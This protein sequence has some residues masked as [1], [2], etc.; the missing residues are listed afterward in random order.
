MTNARRFALNALTMTAS[1]LIMR[2]VSVAFNA[3]VTSK[4]GALGMGLFTLVMSV[5][6]FTV[7]FATSGIYLAC[8]RL[9]AEAIG[10]GDNRGAHL[11]LRRCVIY[12]LSFGSVAT[13]AVF[14]G[15]PFIGN[16]LLGDARTVS[17]LRLLALSMV[18]IA[19][20]TVFNGYFTAIRHSVKNAAAQIFEQTVKI[21]LITWGLMALLPSGL[22]YA[23]I[24]LV[25]GGML[26]EVLSFLFIFAEYRFF[27]RREKE[28]GNGSG[29]S[30]KRLLHISLPVA[31]SSYVRSALVTAEHI[32]IPRA[33]TKR[34]G[35]RD[36][37]IASYGTLHGMAL[38]LVLYPTAALYSFTGLLIPEVSESVAR[39]EVRRIR[40]MTE[41]SISLT[42]FFAMGMSVIIGSAA[43][44][45][46]QLIYGST[47]A[48]LYI[49]AL[50]PLLP[51]MYLDSTVDAVL[52]GLGKQVYSM[53][54]N[55]ID[56]A[57]CVVLVVILLPKFGA[58]GYVYVIY[59]SE[60]LNFILSVKH[61]HDTVHFHFDPV[62]WVLA[63]LAGA[64]ASAAVVSR[65]VFGG[66]VCATFPSAIAKILLTAAI[67]LLLLVALDAFGKDDVKWLWGILCVQKS[68]KTPKI[69]RS[70][71]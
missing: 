64:C 55:I 21:I 48:G 8:T 4:V 1:A 58:I 63:P 68:K 39:G 38:P 18:P 29:A 11:A 13:L 53:A 69:S 65:L 70:D 57:M 67:Y 10:R 60:L 14:F 47:E 23:C 22:E 42:I 52:K 56:A 36:A 26:G 17:S 33:L 71:L 50:A 35:D 43:Y 49:A 51:V 62:R 5:Y 27:T 7:T 54:V 34:G 46:G 16:T 9:V 20:T 45:L 25:G 2:T 40:Y 31:L 30:W 6:N 15:A 28:G 3:Y 61:L 59:A 12:A 66:E 37:A 41:R 44:E 19:L 32:L 24:A